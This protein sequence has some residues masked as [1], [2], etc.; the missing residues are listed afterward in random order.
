[1]IDTVITWCTHQNG[2]YDAD[3]LTLPL[4]DAITITRIAF[5]REFIVGKME[6]AVIE[7]RLVLLG[8]V[9]Y[10]RLSGVFLVSILV[11]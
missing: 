7:K 8:G 5:L 3:G 2:N 6:D 10:V 9:L 1:M 11:V 4:A